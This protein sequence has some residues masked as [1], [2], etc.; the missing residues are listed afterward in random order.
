MKAQCML[1]TLKQVVMRGMV[2]VAWRE[3]HANTDDL[4]AEF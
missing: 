2:R 3:P 4:H 1:Y